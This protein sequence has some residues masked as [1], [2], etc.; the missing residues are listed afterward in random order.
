MNISVAKG[1]ITRP[2]KEIH[3]YL[4]SLRAVLMSKIADKANKMLSWIAL[5]LKKGLAMFWT[6]RDIMNNVLSINFN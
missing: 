2:L 1:F 4:L 6:Q 3:R 5:S